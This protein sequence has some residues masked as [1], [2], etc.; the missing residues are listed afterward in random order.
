MGGFP[1]PWGILTVL[2]AALLGYLVSHVQDRR[3][4]KSEQKR[5][6]SIVFGELQNIRRHYG[7]SAKRAPAS[8][9]ELDRLKLVMTK[10]GPLNM[11]M[12][13]LHQIGF[14]SHQQIADILSLSLVV[15]NNDSQIEALLDE[16]QGGISSGERVTPERLEAFKKRMLF[17]QTKA[18]RL[19]KSIAD[20]HPDLGITIEEGGEVAPT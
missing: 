17:T 18:N 13:S 4:S 11:M 3:K 1:G 12:G 14:L 2:L 8:A 16:L 9:G 7:S 5:M 6:L 10:Y 19:I 15:R 20:N